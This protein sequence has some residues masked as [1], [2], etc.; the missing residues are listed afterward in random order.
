MPRRLGQHFL[1][2]NGVERLLQVIAPRTT[3]AFLE[4]GP[5]LGAL[6]LPLARASR[7]IRAVEL[8]KRLAET[9]QMRSPANVEIVHGDALEVDWVPLLPAGGRIVGNLPY[10]IGSPLL[11][12]VV[13]LHD[14]AFDAHVMVQTEV[15]ERV[16]SPPGVKT[17]GILSV[18]AQLVADVSIPLRLDPNDF[19]PPPEVESAVLRLTFKRPAPIVNL[20]GFREFLERAFT[21][22]RKTLTNNLAPIWPN[23]KEHLKLLD[24][25]GTRRPET[26]AVVEFLGL[27][28]SLR[29][30]VTV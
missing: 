17:Y 18:L 25:E 9:L 5:G 28:E 22:R 10:Y 14:R 13:Q 20:E 8:D 15:A 26:L 7:Q 1:R 16:V 12:R 3:D 6:T 30:T 21:H 11:R 19:E 27:Y 2:T 24:I 29:A 23:L 4:I